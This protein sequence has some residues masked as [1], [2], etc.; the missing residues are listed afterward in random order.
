MSSTLCLIPLR[1]GL[2]AIVLA[3]GI[4]VSLALAQEYS[5]AERLR[6]N[7]IVRVGQGVLMPLNGA[8]DPTD[9]ADVPLLS[10]EVAAEEGEAELTVD[11]PEPEIDETEPFDP[12]PDE[13]VVAS[14][15]SGEEA[16]AVEAATADMDAAEAEP[17]VAANDQMAAEVVGA[18]E[19]AAEM[20]EPAVDEAVAEETAVV[21]EAID[22]DELVEDEDVE[23]PA[24]ITAVDDES[25]AED[26]ETVESVSDEP[27]N[28]T[29][30]EDEIVTEGL[31]AA[32]PVADEPD[33]EELAADE[34]VVGDLAVVTPADDQPDADE[35]D[36]M[37][38]AAVS[39]RSAEL[40]NPESI[41]PYRL[42]LAS[43]KTAREAKDGWRIL[44]E[45]NQELLADLTPIIVLKD[46]GSD[47]GTFFR[48]QAGPLQTQASANT[49]CSA[50]I[51][52]DIY[53]SVLGP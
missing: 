3:L 24:P 33:V 27:D 34:T 20:P 39:P 12:P 14:E 44:A 37:A 46:L 7:D 22:Q 40:G 31:P 48:L 18:P 11:Q 26:L 9:P 42:W 5:G 43:Y 10:D 13:T 4:A 6:I 51:Q 32:A 50:L 52:R 53:C 29:P 45:E 38:I 30:A 16:E 23:D 19:V 15:P 28:G 21:D 2:S 49:R 1:A 25:V 36:D 47:E 41:G 35:P 17:D 8:L